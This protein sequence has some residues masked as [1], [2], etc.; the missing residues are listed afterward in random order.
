MSNI[1]ISI[2]KNS[3]FMTLFNRA[4]RLSAAV[5][6]ISNVMEKDEELRTKIKS[7]SLELVS[8]AVNL[9]D[10]YFVDSKRLIIE[11]EKKSLELMSMLD[12]ASLSGLVSEM[13]GSILKEE[14]QSFDFR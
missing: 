8:V 12:I 5:F 3:D 9:K 14:F 4:Y 6:A 2:P 11:V 1:E 13:N 10:K 7:L